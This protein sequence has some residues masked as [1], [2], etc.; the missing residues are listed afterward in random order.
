MCPVAVL[1]PQ[2]EKLYKVYIYIFNFSASPSSGVEISLVGK[3]L[4]LQHISFFVFKPSCGKRFTKLLHNLMCTCAT[5]PFQQL[6]S[7]LNHVAFKKAK[8]A[9]NQTSSGFETLVASGTGIFTGLPHQQRVLVTE[10]H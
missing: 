6:A 2:S 5:L 4:P 3:R 8:C 1:T 9:Q 7:L 10:V